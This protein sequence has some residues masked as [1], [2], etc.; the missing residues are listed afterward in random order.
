MVTDASLS[1]WNISVDPF[2]TT[3]TV[4]FVTVRRRH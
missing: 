2:D 4:H 3:V 1:H